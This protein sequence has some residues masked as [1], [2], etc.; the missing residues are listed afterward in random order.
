MSP[1]QPPASGTGSFLVSYGAVDIGIIA[2]TAKPLIP[3]TEVIF[4]S[5]ASPTDEVS[6]A[7]GPSFAG[8]VS[9]TDQVAVDYPPPY[10]STVAPTDTVKSGMT[11]KVVDTVTSSDTFSH[12]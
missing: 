3:L 1:K 12:S 4:D 5:E 10:T 9:V 8:G 11:V 6:L 7:H 2:F